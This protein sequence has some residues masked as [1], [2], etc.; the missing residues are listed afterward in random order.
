MKPYLFTLIRDELTNAIQD[1][2]LCCM[3][4]ADKI[5]LINETSESVNQNLDPWRGTS[6][7]KDFTISRSKTEYLHYKFSQHKKSKFEVRL[8][9]IVVQKYK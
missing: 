5:V 6:E 7:N 8:N 4:F 1:E 2:V 9:G 3:V